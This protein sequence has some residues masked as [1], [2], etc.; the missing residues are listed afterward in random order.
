[1]DTI[2]GMRTFVAVVKEGSFTS[3]AKRRDMSTALVSKYVG[4]LEDQLGVRLLNRTTR[5][6]TL[7]EIGAVY[8]ELPATA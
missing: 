5:S 7:T 4:Q 1:M 2:D 3:A 6:L 8:F